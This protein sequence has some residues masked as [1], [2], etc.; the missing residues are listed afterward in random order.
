MQNI[1]KLDKGTLWQLIHDMTVADEQDRT[2][3]IS[4]D[5]DNDG[6]TCI[7]WKIGEGMWTHAYYSAPDPYR[8]LSHELNSRGPMF[9]VVGETSVNRT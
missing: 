4:T 1:V 3:R 9:E 7:K 6:K 8:D 5:T 2:F